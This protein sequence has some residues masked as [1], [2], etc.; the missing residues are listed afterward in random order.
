M[1]DRMD[2]R[3][4]RRDPGM[5]IAIGPMITLGTADV[6]VLKDGWTVVTRDAKPAAHYENTVAITANGKPEILTL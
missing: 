2:G 6:V 5:T 3:G 1:V 4:P